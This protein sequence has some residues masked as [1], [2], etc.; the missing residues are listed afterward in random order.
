MAVLGSSGGCLVLLA[1]GLLPLEFVTLSFLYMTFVL[2]VTA[3]ATITTGDGTPKL[4][5][6]GHSFP[7]LGV[8]LWFHL[9]HTTTAVVAVRGMTRSPLVADRF[10]VEQWG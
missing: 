4:V 1:F 7:I 10:T 3:F 8:L 9:Q 5:L 2:V 6:M